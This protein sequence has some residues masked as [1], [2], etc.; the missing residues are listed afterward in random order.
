VSALDIRVTT[1]P[2]RS[3]AVLAVPVRPG[4]AAG[5]GSPPA[6][7]ALAGL[8]AGDLPE[9]EVAAFLADVRA[10]GSAGRVD[11]LPRPGRQPRTVY[12]V[13]V[14]AGRPADLR[15]AGAA[16]ARAASRQR[17][18][19]A[20]LG[21]CAEPDGLRAVVE[22]LGLAAY[23]FTLA[24]TAKPDGLRRVDLLPA[25]AP[26]CGTAADASP[27]GGAPAAGARV[28]RRTAASRVDGPA[29]AGDAGGP[30]DGRADAVARGLATVRAVHLARDLANTPPA[31]KTPAWLG[32]EAERALAPLGVRVTVRDE[33]WLGV[34]GFGG[35]LAVGGGSVRPPRLIEARW[36]PRGAGGR[37]IVLVGKGITFDTGGLSIK[38]ADVMPP[39]K[40]DMAGGAAVLAAVHAA[41]E[42]RLPVRVTALVPAAENHVSGSAY[43]PADVIRQYGGRTSEVLNTDAEGRIVLADALAYAVARL[44]PDVLV[45]LATLTGA[46]KISLGTRTAG[47]FASDDALAG[48]LLAAA[49]VAGEPAWR[50]PLVD[51]YEPLLRSEIA[52]AVNAPGHGAGAITA[53]LFLRPF[54][55]G[56][57]WAHLDIAGPARAGIDEGEITR[58]AT[59]YGVRTLLRWLE[60]LATSQP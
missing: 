46:M 23:R 16:L 4:A 56:L 30:A 52:D 58:G 11:T 55:G 15:R 57:P 6:A 32:A 37:H 38:P 39:M 25:A 31:E 19:L 14:G 47:L 36:R 53:A 21:D 10:D 5:G 41:A 1:A 42:L 8:P 28:T 26:G 17:R 7:A 3:A 29:A 49:A 34:H 45:D 20:A 9:A 13:G 60:S 18:V 54:T 40:T 48:E 2:D 24:T 22:G 51:D 35:L 33:T 12:L 27:A 50:M 59:G 43:R 44:A